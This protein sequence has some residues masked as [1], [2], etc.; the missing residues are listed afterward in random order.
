MLRQKFENCFNCDDLVQIEG[1]FASWKKSLAVPIITY[2]VVCRHV[3]SYHVSVISHQP[4]YRF[5]V[6]G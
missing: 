1:A 3:H 2:T 6:G 5:Y 4:L